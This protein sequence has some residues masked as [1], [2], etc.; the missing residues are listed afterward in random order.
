MVEVFFCKFERVVVSRCCNV[1]RWEITAVQAQRSL[2]FPVA[3]EKDPAKKTPKCWNSLSQVYLD[4]PSRST[5]RAN[6][7]GRKVGNSPNGCQVRFLT[8]IYHPNI[9]GCSDVSPQQTLR[10]EGERSDTWSE[11]P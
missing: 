2:G 3:T 6:F 10:R 8:K 11:G 9:A 5:G 4:N 1:I 7:P